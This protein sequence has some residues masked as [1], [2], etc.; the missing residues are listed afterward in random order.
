MALL[1][2]QMMMAFLNGYQNQ[3]MVMPPEDPMTAHS[4]W[5][6]C[7]D[8]QWV[9]MSAAWTGEAGWREICHRI[10]RPELLDDPRFTTIGDRLTHSAEL[11]PIIDATLLTR[12]AEDW[13]TRFVG[14]EGNFSRIRT[15]LRE[16]AGDPHMR[17]NRYVVDDDHPVLGPITTLGVI[18]D[19]S[20]TPGALRMPPP[21]LGQHTEEVLLDVCGYDWNKI[22]EL[23]Q[24]GA[25][26]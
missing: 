10:D 7:Q 21:E 8:D 24:L 4:G 3:Q 23:Q 25:I 2:F 16:M 13:E 5:F 6:R 17:A 11:R 19:F 20:E 12:T 14:F 15:N 18:P 1:R 9:F 22:A 26:I